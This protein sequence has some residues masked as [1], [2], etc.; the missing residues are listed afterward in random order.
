MI[1]AM[2]RRVLEDLLRE[3]EEAI[4]ATDW[5][6]A[7]VC[8]EEVL[9]QAEIPDALIG[10]SKVAMIDREYDRAI[11]LKERAFEGYR[12]NGQLGPALDAASWLAFMYATYLGNFSVAMGWKERAAGVLEGSE[13]SAA[14]GWLAMLEAPFSRD[15]AERERLA[16]T[17]LEIARHFGDVDLEIEAL[18]LRGEAHVVAGRVAEGMS[19]LDEAMAAVTAGRVRDHFALGEIYC[20]LLSACEAALDVRRATEW[21]SML[22]RYVVWTDFVRPTCR[23]HYGGILIA[24][25]RWPEAEAELL[26]AID[27]FDRGYRGDRVFAAMRLAELRVRQGRV[28]EAERLL[29][30]GE[31]HPTARRL[32]TTIALVRG[33]VVLAGE[34]GELCAEGSDLT[35]PTAAPA[36]ELLIATRLALGNSTAARDA[37]DRLVTIARESG[38]DRLEACAALADGRVRAAQGDERAPAALTRAVELF[39]SLGL[40]LEAARAQLEL[41]RALSTSAPAA[42]TR[43]GKLALAAFNRLGARAD[44]DAAAGLLRGFGVASGRSWPRGASGLTVREREVLA[45]LAEGCSNAQIAERLVISVRTAE[46]H[47]ASILSKLDLGSRAEAAAYAVRHGT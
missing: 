26:A 30:G 16:T 32:A 21:L 19:L 13:E 9:A 38:L 46:H 11:A 36:L 4:V 15:A 1:G 40:P 27:G 28:E 47:V 23:T 18:A 7:R 17:A 20:R 31:W 42:A 25:G 24:L 39:G 43:E 3:G 34:L 29:E 8:L 22:D 14:H 45:L 44:A 33:D 5:E 2:E 12:R 41:A 37:A 10:L 35:D 6:R